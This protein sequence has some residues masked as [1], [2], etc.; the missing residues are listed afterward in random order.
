[1]EFYPHQLTN[2]ADLI[3]SIRECGSAI[4]AS[5]TGTGK[6]I[7]ALAV[8]HL[9]KKQ[10]F[11][12]CPLGV[13]PGWKDKAGMMSTAG[14]CDG[15]N[16][17]NYEKART[18][19]GQA[20][21]RAELDPTRDLI[22][23]DEA[24]RIGSPKSLQALLAVQLKN[25][26]FSILCLT[27]TPFD[28]PLKSRAF[29][30]LTNKVDWDSWYSS[31]PNWGCVRCNWI[32]GKPWQFVGDKQDMLKLK[33]VLK[34][35]IVATGWADVE[36]FPD[37]VVD[38]VP[39][40]ITKADARR[41]DE[42]RAGLVE[43]NSGSTMEIRAELEMIRVPAMVSLARDE[44]AQG[45]KVVAFFNFKAPLLSFAAETGCTY[46][47]GSVP[48]ADREN[49]R[50]NHQMS[51]TPAIIACNGQA[52][53]EGL[54]LHD[55]GHGP[56]VT[57]ISPPHSAPILLQEFGRTHR[58]GGQSKAVHKIIFAAGTMEQHKLMPRVM[59][60]RENI[61]TLTTADLY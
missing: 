46:I 20:K 30:H 58:A 25:A 34:G 24:H 1:M 59:A 50:K 19:K 11:V 60:R 35:C 9:L 39:V 43:G 27:A 31:I 21:L 55:V 22:V 52:A 42:I 33:E 4:D 2:A 26:G 10:A 48:P 28:N 29:L 8:A 7:T 18:A 57:I 5:S 32:R 37:Y 47:D 12:I 13:G 61:E 23:F 16:W 38:C 53:G 49:L 45:N 17:T 6:S 40:P 56:V 51:P 14:Y 3:K 54:D 36:G 44:I 15:F 41:V